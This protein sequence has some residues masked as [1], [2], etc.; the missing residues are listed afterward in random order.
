MF[1]RLSVKHVPNET[2]IIIVTGL[3]L[4][5]NESNDDCHKIEPE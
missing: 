1:S 2:T 4:Y 5:Y 3:Q